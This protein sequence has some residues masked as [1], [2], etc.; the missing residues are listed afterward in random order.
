MQEA[1]FKMT[2]PRIGLA[3]GGG[4]ARGMSHIPV[5]QAFDDLGVKPC[6]ITGSSIGALLGAGYAAGLSGTELHDYA[7][8]TFRHRNALIARLWQLRPKRFTDMFTGGIA[9]FDPLKVVNLFAADLIPDHFEDLKIP[10]TVLATDFYGCSEIDITTGPLR[11]A[12]AASIAIPAVFRAVEM[13]G[14]VL[15]DGGIANPLPFDILPADCGITVAV[16]V[17]GVPVPRRTHKN[18]PATLDSLFGSS[19]ILMRTITA[20]KLKQK[21]PDILVR[22]AVDDIRVLDF[23]KTRMVLESAAP[24]RELVKKQLSE[25]LEKAA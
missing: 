8:E 16:D 20:E 23:M 3:L 6:H 12:I 11:P 4:G 15:V 21:R 1:S 10:L 17:V 5:F 9:Q 13:G 18:A 24:L 22:P 25:L 2:Y 19:Q 14:K 7:L